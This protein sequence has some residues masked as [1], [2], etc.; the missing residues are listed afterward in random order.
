MRHDPIDRILK[1]IDSF[2]HNQSA[3]GLVLLIST[4]AAVALANSPWSHEYHAIWEH[5]I[6]LKVAGF[7]VERTIHHVINDGLMAVFFFL[8]ALELK[9]EFV[10]GELSEP[11]NALLPLAASVGGMAIPALIYLAM[12]QFA[13]PETAGWGIP[14]GTDTA[15]VLGLLALLGK[16]VPPALKVFFI[17]VSV[18]DDIGSVTVIALFYTSDIELQKL[19]LGAIFLVALISMNLLGVRNVIAYGV[20]GI[21]GVWLAFLLSGVHATVAGVLAALTIPARTKIQEHTYVVQLRELADDFERTESSPHATITSEQQHL[22]RKIRRMSDHA[23]T[24]LQ[25]LEQALHP[26]V[27]YV[28]MPLFALAN[29]GIELPSSVG[30]VLSSPITLG[31]LLGLVLGKPLGIVGL[32]F[33]VSKLGWGRLGQGLT[34]SHVIGIGVMSGLG[35]TMSVFINELAFADLSMQYAAKLGILF[36]SLIAGP[37][38]FLLLRRLPVGGGVRDET[39]PPA[40]S[41]D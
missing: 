41:W 17:T 34:W 5:T 12:N 11:W 31:V 40:T 32:A 35:F 27:V 38:G 21:A 36:A 10:G 14:M 2:I 19:V 13:G 8:V 4:A 30:D 37:L 1:P 39:R 29:A 23:E 24:P 18:A 6:S 25:R 3:A 20:V 33:L 15:F 9:R 22:I 16:R 7:V 28:V 26:W